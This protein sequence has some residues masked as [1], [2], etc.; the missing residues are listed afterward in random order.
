LQN[1]LAFLSFF[2]GGL[3]QKKKIMNTK[4][5]FKYIFIPCDSGKPVEERE[6]DSSGGLSNDSL[7]GTAK[8]YFESLGG[9]ANPNPHRI[10]QQIMAAG[11]AEHA[12]NLSDAELMS[13]AKG[14]TTCEIIALTVP[15]PLNK[16]QAV[17]MYGD[18]NSRNKNFPLNERATMLRK[19]CGN[20]GD[21]QVFGDVFVGR[22]IDNE[23]KDIWKRIDFIETD[24]N[25]NSEWCKVARMK[26]GGSYSGNGMSYNPEAAAA[27]FLQSSQ[28]QQGY[29]EQELQNG[30]KWSQSDEEVELKLD[31]IPAGTKAKY[32]KVSFTK[33][34]LKVTLTGQTL[35]NGKTGGEVDVSDSTWTI[36]DN[37]NKR[38]LCITL[39]K[40]NP[41][42]SWTFAVK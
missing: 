20:V 15:T 7:Q 40:K 1:G 33:L 19:Y 29:H 9:N 11:M 32:V 26:G 38:E 8:K 34:S 16:H 6:G 13:M 35:V 3:S 28:Q 39:S 30:I 37:A 14:M 25:E 24:L 12:K 42:K 2:I 22:C 10:R 17:S 4:N 36:Q 21:I 23:A 31:N 5:V 27:Q 18:D 41:G